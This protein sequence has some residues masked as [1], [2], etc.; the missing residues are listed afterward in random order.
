[1]TQATEESRSM[2]NEFATP[3]ETEE[4]A[5]IVGGYDLIAPDFAFRGTVG[6]SSLLEQIFALRYNVY[7]LECGFLDP[8][9]YPS[10]HETDEYDLGASHFTAHTH[11]QRLVGAVRLVHP[12]GQQ[13]FPFQIRCQPL[14]DNITLPKRDECA[15]IS[16]LVVAKSH[17]RRPGDSIT[18]VAQEFMMGRLLKTS[19]GPNERR[20]T[21]PQ[22]LLG[23]YREMYY[24]S[25]QQGIRYWYA[26]MELP[27]RR[28]LSH[29]GFE[30]TALGPPADYY[31]LV[32]PYITD[33][34]ALESRLT[35]ASPDLAAWFRQGCTLH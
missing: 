3:L 21:S 32:T 11:D 5:P 26:A 14:F 34:R 28:V 31:G 8:T 24:Y 10:G 22:I 29:Y 1:M 2:N 15:E 20:I 16:R 19:R 17:R 35:T 18:G 25:V 13:R 9:A 23:M 33:L 30:F 27:L 12:F 6:R 7:C 4:A